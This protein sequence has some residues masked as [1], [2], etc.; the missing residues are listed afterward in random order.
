M[1][2][3]RVTDRLFGHSKISCIY[4]DG[5]PVR[6]LQFQKTGFRRVFRQG[7]ARRSAAHEKE[8]RQSDNLTC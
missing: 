3:R 1:R 7:S 4:A 8:Q 6:F 2:S 5:L